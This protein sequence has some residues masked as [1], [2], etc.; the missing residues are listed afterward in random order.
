MATLQ[1]F[2]PTRASVSIAALNVT[3]WAPDTKFEITPTNSRKT[4]TEGVDGD[5]S[6]N[7]DSRYSGTLTINLL[8]NASFNR[9]LT[10]LSL[11][12]DQANFPFFPVAISDPT[13]GYSLI[14]QG[15][16]QDEPAHSVAQETGTKTWTIGLQDTR[17]LPL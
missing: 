16:I 17:G 3:G 10:T 12:T 11:G 7:I 9:V 15:W 4:V 8:Q 13:S 2:D 6:V 14:T 1:S 5:I